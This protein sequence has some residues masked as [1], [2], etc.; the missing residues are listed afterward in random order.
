MAYQP[1]FAHR[2]QTVKKPSPLRILLTLIL[3]PLS[4][5]LTGLLLSGMLLN[6]ARPQA[7]LPD[8]VSDMTIAP[9]FEAFVSAELEEARGS[10]TAQEIPDNAPPTEATIPPYEVVYTLDDALQAGPEPNQALFGETDDPSTLTE[11]LNQ[12][13]Y[14]LDGQELF[15]TT[16]VQLFEGSVVRY[17]LDETIFAINW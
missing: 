2:G 16:D 15:F 17:Y 1:K 9:G 10:L 12:A 5:A 4:L 14:I 3:V 6:L 13:K 11:V 7:I 8:T